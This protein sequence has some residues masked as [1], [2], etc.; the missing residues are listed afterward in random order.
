MTLT[1]SPWVH[2]FL[3]VV[4][5]P[6]AERRFRFH[7]SCGAL[8]ET[9]AHNETCW[10]CGRSTE[11]WYLATAKGEKCFVRIRRYRQQQRRTE[12]VVLPK[13]PRK[14]RDRIGI[15]L[16]ILCGVVWL[17]AL[18]IGSLSWEQPHFYERQAAPHM[19]DVHD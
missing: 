10:N 3:S 11:V 14:S 17:V 2:D 19:G 5:E 4:S 16:Q 7:C 13:A 8:I 9:R 1:E 18:L 6:A 15:A 12:P